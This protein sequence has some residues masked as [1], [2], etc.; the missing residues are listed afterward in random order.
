MGRAS[1]RPWHLTPAHASPLHG[2]HFA[3]RRYYPEQIADL[4]ASINAVPCDTVIIATPMDLRKIINIEKP[5]TVVRKTS[6]TGA[7][8][9]WHQHRPVFF[10]LTRVF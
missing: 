8:L 7:I 10:D 1:R 5:A 4:E 9:G 3:V 6:P 2:G